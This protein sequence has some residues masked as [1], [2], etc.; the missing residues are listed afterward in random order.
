MNQKLFKDGGTH[1]ISNM[2][3]RRIHLR[4][5]HK[6]VSIIFRDFIFK[7]C[8]KPSLSI[9]V[10]MIFAIISPSE[11]NSEHVVTTT[12]VLENLRSFRFTD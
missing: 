9:R 7:N 1:I 2:H 10:L 11:F 4:K 8:M 12:G 5:Y 3:D 6:A